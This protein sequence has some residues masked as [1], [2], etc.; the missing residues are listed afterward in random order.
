[1]VRHHKAILLGLPPQYGI[2]DQMTVLGGQLPKKTK[3]HY[4]GKSQK[5]VLLLMAVATWVTKK[6]IFSLIA[7]S[8]T[9]PPLL[10]ARPLRE[11]FFFC[12]FPYEIE[13]TVF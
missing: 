10:M 7:R 1:M 6:V 4:L 5:K 8:F 12:G 11:E 13:Q 3:E 9:P 2:C